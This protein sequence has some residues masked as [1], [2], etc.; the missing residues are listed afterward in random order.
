[1]PALI[2]RTS[3]LGAPDAAP[4]PERPA[5]RSSGVKRT[6]AGLP[7]DLLS[8]I[9][10]DALGAAV[11]AAMRPDGSSMKMAKSWALS[12]SS[13]KRSSLSRSASSARLR[14]V[15]S[16][17]AATAPT[18]LPSHRAS[19]RRSSRAMPLLIGPAKS[20]LLIEHGFACGKRP[21]ERPLLQS[22]R[23]AVGMHAAQRRVSQP[24]SCG[25]RNGNG[26]RLIE[27]SAAARRLAKSSW[28][29][30]RFGHQH[31]RRHLLDDRLQA[32]LCRCNI[33]LGVLARGD[34][35][36]GDDDTR[37]AIIFGP[38]GQRAPQV[39]ATA[40]AYALPILWAAGSRG[41]RAP[42]R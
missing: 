40:V 11:P 20:N 38:I 32:R 23:P 24:S 1:M 12:T 14:S 25:P 36:E 21:R 27:H 6:A 9:P 8:L 19:A 18:T 35:D 26:E 33:L 13:R 3:G 42:R 39:P 34:L 41:P 15:I 4:V 30:W 31:R 28:L 22:V 37:D 10:C 7:E 2:Q 5:A 29:L 16:Q 17:N